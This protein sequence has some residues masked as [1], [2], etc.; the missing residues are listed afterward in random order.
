MLPD[1]VQ[2]FSVRVALLKMPPPKMPPPPKLL[3]LP[4]MVQLFQR[5]NGRAAF[6]DCAAAVAA[7][8]ERE[9]GKGAGAADH[10]EDA[11]F[12]ARRQPSTPAPLAVGPVIVMSLLI[13]G[14]KPWLNAMVCLLAK[15]VASEGD[16]VIRQAVAT[17]GVNRLAERAIGRAASAVVV[18]VGLVDHKVRPALRRFGGR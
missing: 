1:S 7:I 12:A 13:S 2:E 9:V 6:L 18:I 11:A 10:A 14:N 5:Q 4:A 15:T 3:V 17:G 16:D 8:D